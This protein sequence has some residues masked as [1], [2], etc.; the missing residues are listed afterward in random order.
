MSKVR[1]S[2]GDGPSPSSTE[3]SLVRIGELARRTGIPASTLRAWERRYGVITPER[4]DSGYRLYDED[5]E[6]RLR[7]M[8]ELVGSGLA[9]AEAA[10]RLSSEITATGPSAVAAGD[11][12]VELASAVAAFDERRADQALDRA[13]T[14]LSTDSLLDDVLLPVLRGL[15]DGTVGQEHFASNLIRGRLLA[16]ARGWG[17]GSGRLALLACPEGELHDLSLIAFGLA[18]RARGWRVSFLGA[19][20]PIEALAA[21]AAQVEP[22]LVVL[23]AFD[24]PLL[25]S[26]EADLRRLGKRYR[27]V[28]AGPGASDELAGRAGVARLAEDPVGA[29]EV[30]AAA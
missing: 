25:E 16:L 18:L 2:S 9:P 6:R 22:E 28:V 21:A 20:T 30:L 13:V 8:V 19:N 15:A 1:P 24:A 27:V 26:V 23:S 17:G 11:L 4:G 10:R 5:D 12:R 29:A 7:R 14:L 3:S